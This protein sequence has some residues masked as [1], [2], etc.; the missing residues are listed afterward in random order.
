MAELGHQEEEEEV[1]SPVGQHVCLGQGAGLN[2]ALASAQVLFT[3][4]KSRRKTEWESDT[5]KSF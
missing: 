1:P 4:L 5:S 2:R 3:L